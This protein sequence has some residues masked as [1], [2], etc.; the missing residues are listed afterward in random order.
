[1]IN[2]DI[3]P[4]TKEEKKKKKLSSGRKKRKK[5]LS[6]LQFLVQLLLLLPQLQLEHLEECELP[7][8]SVS[9]CLC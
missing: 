3:C 6:L 2:F 1:M 8:E 7:S 4:G 5:L 9:V